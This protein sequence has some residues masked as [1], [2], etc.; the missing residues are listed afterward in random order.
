MVLGGKLAVKEMW[1]EGKID[2]HAKY[3]EKRPYQ[4]FSFLG[5][6]TDVLMQ[7]WNSK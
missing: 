6:E 3:T 5:S 4:R 7:L 1:D 2:G